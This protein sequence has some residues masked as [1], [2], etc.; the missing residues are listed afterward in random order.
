MIGKR[1]KLLIPSGGQQAGDVGIIKSS[2]GCA[3][4]GWKVLFGNMRTIEVKQHNLG[5]TYVLVEEV[6]EAV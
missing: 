6:K 4:P 5:R 2:C 1:V 3:V